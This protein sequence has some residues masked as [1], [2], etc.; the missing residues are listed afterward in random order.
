MN[1]LIPSIFF[2]ILDTS[3]P[4]LHAIQLLYRVCHPQDFFFTFFQTKNPFSQSFKYEILVPRRRLKTGYK[5]TRRI[6]MHL[7]LKK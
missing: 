3:P 4:P 5:S 7:F 6:F 2:P 1:I